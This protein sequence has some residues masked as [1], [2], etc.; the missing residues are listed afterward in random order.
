MFRLLTMSKPL[1]KRRSKLKQPQ[2]KLLRKV[3]LKPLLISQ[4][5]KLIEEVKEEDVVAEETTVG[6]MTVRTASTE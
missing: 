5:L 6:A 1:P 3:K 4:L 2:T